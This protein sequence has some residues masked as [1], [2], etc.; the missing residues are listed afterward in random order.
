MEIVIAETER[1]YFLCSERPKSLV[2]V[3]NVVAK[4]Y[5]SPG[6]VY[7]SVHYLRLFHFSSS[8]EWFFIV[9]RT[10]F[11]SSSLRFGI[12]FVLP[13]FWDA[14]SSKCRAFQSNVLQIAHRHCHSSQM[15]PA[16]L[17]TRTA[18]HCRKRISIS[19]SEIHSESCDAAHTHQSHRFER[20]SVNWF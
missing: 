19:V 13:T 1:M 16:H 5:S 4:S 20:I 18:W 14:T 12:S 3:G 8:W 17:A 6:S 9:I 11:E 7:P 2:R 15:E 10:I